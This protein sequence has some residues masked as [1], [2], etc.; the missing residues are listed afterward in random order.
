VTPP[1]ILTPVIVDTN[2]LVVG[3]LSADPEAPT[4]RILDGM[5]RGDF[6]Y[7]LSIDLLAEY[8]LVLLRDRIRRRHGLTA[9]EVD[10]ILTV[11]AA[12][13]IVREPLG[14]EESAP[15]PGDQHLWD[16]LDATPGAGLVTGNKKLVETPSAN[17][18]ILGPGEFVESIAGRSESF[19]RRWRGRFR[20]A[21]GVNNRSSRLEKKKDHDS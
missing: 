10:V 12:I 1:A 4:A 14:S 17:R 15:E 21:D 6:P 5:L 18:T 3:L 8:R 7:V 20:E 19:A 11:L 9:D 13:A 2:V 16:L